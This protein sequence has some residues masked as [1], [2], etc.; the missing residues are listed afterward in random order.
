MENALTL[1]RPT[2]F[3]DFREKNHRNARGFEREFLR[4]DKLG[5]QWREPRMRKTEIC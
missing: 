5:S 2:A 3:G 4:S 1:W